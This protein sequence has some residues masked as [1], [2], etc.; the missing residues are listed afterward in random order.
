VKRSPNRLNAIAHSCSK[1][2][3]VSLTREN[4]ATIEEIVEPWRMPVEREYRVE[5]ETTNEL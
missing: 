1:T 2:E 3:Q 4:Y 5:S